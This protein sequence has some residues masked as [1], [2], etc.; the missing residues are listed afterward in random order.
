[1][2]SAVASAALPRPAPTWGGRSIVGTVPLLAGRL[3]L[4]VVGF[5]GMRIASYLISFAIMLI[6][7][8]SRRNTL[9]YWK[10]LRPQDDLPTQYG[11]VWRHF[12]CF[13]RLFCDRML[14]WSSGAGARLSAVGKER[15]RTAV[16]DGR[17]RIVLS[18][19]LGNWAVAGRILGRWGG[20]PVHVV[21]AELEGE[22]ERAIYESVMGDRAPRV[23]DPRDPVGATLAIHAAL[24]RGETVGMLADRV[25]GGQPHVR[26]PFLGREARIPVGPFQVAAATGAPIYVV[27]CLRAGDNAYRFVVDEPWTLELPRDRA[28]RAAALRAAAARWAQRL[29]REVRLR[30]LQ[31]TNFHDFWA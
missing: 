25:Y 23:I 16:F 21:K 28:G 30:P 11:R 17:G 13:G 24:S 5:R 7:A 29:E 2:S 15:L 14:L 26:V 1:M 9:C 22:R 8:R 3:V 12:S 6:D 20:P 10:R 19:H 18:A 4:R 27:F 31:W